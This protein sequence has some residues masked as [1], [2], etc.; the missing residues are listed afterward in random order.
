MKITFWGTRGSLA[1]AGPDTLRYGGNTACVALEAAGAPLVVLDA[2]SGIRAL[3]ASVGADITS[4]HILLSHLH[5]DHI[6]GLG[7]FAPLFRPGLDVHL[8]GPP[9][10]TMSLRERLTR[11]LSPPLFP[12]ALRDLPCALTLHDA[13]TQEPFPVG[14][15][16]VS[17]ALVIHP[18]PTVGYRI[19][20]GRATVAYLPDHEPALG[21]RRFPA[22]GRWLSGFALARGADLLIHDAQYTEPE[23]Y[24]RVGWGHSTIDHAVSLAR[25]AAVKRLATF[26]HDP[27][28]DDRALDA[29]L[30]PVTG[31]DA[32]PEV[33]AAREGKVVTL[34]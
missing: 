4:V 27:G 30:A 6:Q 1:V 16:T 21:T 29:T 25:L 13:P 34:S 9:S 23:Y 12:V 28:H 32:G 7:F 24:A 22:S 20:D 2:G 15:L 10:V 19:S 26:H 8:W 18:G 5:M 33:S 17:A 31:S 14:P 11:Y 3:G